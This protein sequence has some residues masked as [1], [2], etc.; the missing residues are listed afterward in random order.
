[1]I[2]QT[3][4]SQTAPTTL[5]GYAM[6]TVDS[7]VFELSPLTQIGTNGNDTMTALAG[8]TAAKPSITYGLDGDDKITG[9]A[10]IDHI[11]G[12]EGKDILQGVGGHDKIDGGGGNDIVWGGGDGDILKGGAGDDYVAAD[13]FSKNVTLEGGAGNDVMVGGYGGGC[14]VDGGT[15]NDSFMI[16]ATA[17]GSADNHYI[18]GSGWDIAS[19]DRLLYQPGTDAWI[20]QNAKGEYVLHWTAKSGAAQT[21][22]V[23]GIEQFN[24]GGTLYTFSQ[25]L[26]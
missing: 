20:D 15:G 1:V 8:G 13:A 14:I 24:I 10:G 6:T 18:G 12:G 7:F 3:I 19:L 9:S 17:G 26:V 22:I 21:D 4:A 2:N 16:R 25:L 5:A 23:D 11:Y